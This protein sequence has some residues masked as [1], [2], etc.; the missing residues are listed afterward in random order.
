MPAASIPFYDRDCQIRQ[1]GVFGDGTDFTKSPLSTACS[2]ACLPARA[3]TNASP[4]NTSHQMANAGC[5]KSMCPKLIQ[6]TTSRGRGFSTTKS[7]RSLNAAYGA[8][9]N[10]YNSTPADNV[11]EC[12]STCHCDAKCQSSQFRLSV[13]TCWLYDRPVAASARP[14]GEE[15]STLLF[16]DRSCPVPQCGV[17]GD[18][19]DFYTSSTVE[20]EKQCILTCQK[21]SKCFFSEYK[22]SNVSVKQSRDA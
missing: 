17:Y 22:P 14:A 20:N 16:N 15:Y 6:R 21:E 19:T 1:C 5:T 18:G 9:A 7:V 13:S 8:G 3:T 12:I 4:L 10:S 2:S 11:Q